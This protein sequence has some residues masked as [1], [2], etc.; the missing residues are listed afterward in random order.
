MD[1]APAAAGVTVPPDRRADAIL[2]GQAGQNR[3]SRINEEA[4]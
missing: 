4:G 2:V 1:L 3:A